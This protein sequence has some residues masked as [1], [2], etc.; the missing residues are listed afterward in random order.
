[1]RLTARPV[2]NT[3]PVNVIV[4]GR[5]VLVVGGGRVGLRK[6]TTLLSAGAT[7]ELVC[8]TAAEELEKLASS[9]S[10]IW[11]CREFVVD[12][13]R[14]RLLVYAC[15]DD[16]HVNRAV[17]DA[18]REAHVPCGCSDGNWAD[19]DFTTPATARVGDVVLAVSTN[20]KSCRDAR[21]IKEDLVRSISVADPELVVI[22]TSDAV[23]A[24]RK[25][26]PLHL[27]KDLRAQVGRWI[28]GARGVREFLIL[29]TCNR[30]ELIAYA[31][32]CEETVSLL[33]RII[34]FD[35]LAE[36][37]HFV[38]RGKEAFRH[39]VRVASGLESSLLGEFHVVSQLKDA[40]SEAEAEGWSGP[41]VRGLGD[42]M[43]RVSKLVRHEVE[44]LLHVSEID[45]VAVRYL[46]KHGGLDEK[47]R[48]VVIGT[49]V[50]GTGAV[51]SL[52]ALGC[53]LAVV[54]HS[55]KPESDVES[56]PM[57]NL[58]EALKGADYVISAVDSS[59]P[60]LAVDEAAAF[61]G[62]PVLLVDLGVP[63]NID[64]ILDDY[65]HGVTVADLDDL[66]LWHRVK[67]GTLDEVYARADAVITR[68]QA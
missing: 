2:R 1:M 5:S 39:L 66:K 60:V 36:D 11:Q 61:A 27:P 45:Q 63:R 46:A 29:N 8:P 41:R 58:A 7:V 14:G 23:L 52:Q 48:V 33:K 64:P 65:G 37:E 50:V 42:D 17:L 12:D 53:Q 24:S 16:K 22:G 57:A 9:G 19:G 18:A 51:R 15:T 35:R 67:N 49:G 30:I 28:R 21:E 44:P 55:R 62:R 54:Y 47:S 3:I 40:F 10:I 43:L 13:V 31:D 68:E 59:R 32:S 25:R 38:L 26:A 20:G 56:Y 34:G 6:V 4:D